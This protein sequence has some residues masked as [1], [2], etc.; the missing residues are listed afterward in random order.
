[1]LAAF[2][3]PGQPQGDTQS[4]GSW[5]RTG[6]W[7][8]V[9]GQRD[10]T[11]SR[12]TRRGMTPSDEPPTKQRRRCCGLPV[13][14]FV[15]VLLLMICIIVAAV[16]VPLEFFVLKNWGNHN[17]SSESD[18]SRCQSTLNCQNGGT[19][20]IPQGVCSCICTNGFTG[21]DCSAGGSDGCT[22][23]D[24]ASL[25][26]TTINNVTLG[27]AIPRLIQGANTN[28]SIPLSGTAILAKLNTG[29]LSCMAQNSLVTFDG[30]SIRIGAA[31]S[32]VES[33]E[34]KL[35]VAGEKREAT[36]SVSVITVSQGEAEATLVVDVGTP[37]GF[38]PTDGGA[39]ATAEPTATRTTGDGDEPSITAAPTGKPTDDFIVTEEVLD[40]AR[41]AVLYV[42]QEE[43]IDSAGTAQTKLQAFF[44][45]ADSKAGVTK[46]QATNVQIGGDNSINFIAYTMNI[47]KGAI[48]GK[49]V[50]RDLKAML[51][52]E[53]RYV[54]QGGRHGGAVLLNR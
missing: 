51:D 27:K 12:S 19:N 29:D 14:A 47:G 21:S 5:F 30:H 24:L 9:P 20:V 31:S 1:M 52:S 36:S 18:L 34:E 13:W 10:G 28:F 39:S 6:S 44:S 37:S 46:S 17:K 2:P 48:G 54:Q 42:L 26:G 7:P 25:D 53:G 22:T 16:V 41:V 49:V 23:T 35:E 4:R 15:V 38:A 45:N 40:F 11:N 33:K 32:P 8:L 3:P 43:N 50:K